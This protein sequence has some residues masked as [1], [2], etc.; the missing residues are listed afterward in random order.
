MH[1][2]Y[3]GDVRA[4]TLSPDGK[5]LASLSGNTVRLWDPLTRTALQTLQF[6]YSMVS[7]LAFSPNSKQL[8]SVSG[9]TVWLWGLATGAAQ[10]LESNRVETSSSSSCYIVDAL[11]FSPHSKLLASTSSQTVRL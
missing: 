1:E 11:A 8:A 10:T 7:I 6:H 9:D 5:L 2:G 4:L 3:S